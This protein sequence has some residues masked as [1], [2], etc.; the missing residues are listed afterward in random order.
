MHL[1]LLLLLGWRWGLLLLLR[2]LGWV[3]VR[4]LGL[5][6]RAGQHLP[7]HGRGVD[8]KGLGLRAAD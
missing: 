4:G 2:L 7:A 6:R 1:L 8:R 5:G 3:V